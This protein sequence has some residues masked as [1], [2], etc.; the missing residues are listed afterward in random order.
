MIYHYHLYQVTTFKKVLKFV[1]RECTDIYPNE[2]T[3]YPFLI[4]NVTSEAIILSNST[5]RNLMA[6]GAVKHTVKFTKE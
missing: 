4:Q 3:E 2:P 1:V 5:L 6:V